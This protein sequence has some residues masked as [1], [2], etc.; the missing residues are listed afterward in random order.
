MGFLVFC[1]DQL[2]KYW[3]AQRLSPGEMIYLI[4]GF[5]Q[6][7][8]VRNYGAAFGILPYHTSFF[9]VI[10]ILMALMIIIFVPRFISNRFVLLRTALALLLGGTLGNL[11]DRIVRGYI[12][13]FFDFRI[14]PVFNIA[15][16]ALV[17]GIA[18]VIFS[19]LRSESLF[20]DH[21]R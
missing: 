2:S 5:F 14:W 12:I 19:L 21:K 8:F 1:A 10:K 7:T 3:V 20:Q 11:L 16:I 13:D 15:D 17:L 9:I 18:L 6:L 4:P